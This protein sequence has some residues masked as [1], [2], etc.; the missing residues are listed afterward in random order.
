MVLFDSSWG[1]A[2][3]LRG[4]I[5]TDN[6]VIDILIK[7]PDSRGVPLVITI[8]VGSCNI[9]PSKVEF[10]GT[11]TAKGYKIDKVN[12]GGFFSKGVAFE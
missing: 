3:I 11:A 7:K 6:E 10:H 8:Y 9:L 5:H 1:F 2:V 4:L 12:A